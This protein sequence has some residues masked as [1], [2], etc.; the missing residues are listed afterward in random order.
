MMSRK[1]VIMC[2][3]TIIMVAYMGFAMTVSTRMA[4]ADT[5]TGMEVVLSDPQSRFVSVRDVVLESGI[6]P[7][8]LRYCRR[9]GFDLHSLEQRL[10]ASD[11]LQD[12]N[13]TLLSDGRVKID[14][15]PMVP[16]A[17][18]FEP[19][20]PSY[21]INAGGKRIS[22]ELRYHIDVPVLV[23]SFDSVYPAQRLLPLLDYIASHRKAG[24][25]IA[26][27]TQEADGNIILIP[28]IVG[29]VV[30][31]GDTSRVSEKFAMLRSFYRSVAPVKGWDTYDTVAVKWRGQVVATRRNKQLAP[32]PLPIESEQTGIL[33]INDNETVAKS[34]P[35]EQAGDA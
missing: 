29:H 30:N 21:Y 9:E 6:D 2:V 31:F 23:G 22:A 4:A 35:E 24:A 5:L 20:K 19:G 26:T 3:L 32:V 17:R 25:M 27:V 14:V 15:T 28:T 16:V 1:S 10:K 13:A 8:T 33:D 7:D 12:A 34:T 11:K 18:V